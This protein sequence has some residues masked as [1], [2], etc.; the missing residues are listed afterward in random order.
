M[1]ELLQKQLNQR[2]EANALR[3]LP[4]LPGL[5]DFSSNDYLGLA[6]IDLN[7]SFHKNGSGGSRLISGNSKLMEQIEEDLARFYHTPSALLF[8]SG[9]D[10]NVGL[11]SCLL[12]KG[13]TYIYDQ[14]IHAS[15][16]DGMRL[17]NANSYAFRH[18]D[19]ESLAA[20]LE[21][22]KGR[23]V[24]VIESI[25]SMDGDMAPIKEITALCDRNNAELIVD[26]AHSTGVFGVNGC[27][28]VSHYGLQD[29]VYAR[30][31]T[32]GKAMGCHGAVIVGSDVLKSY[33]VNF[34]RSFIYTTALPEHSVQTIAEVHKRMPE[35]GDARKALKQNISLFQDCLDATVKNYL[36]PS[37]SAIQCILFADNDK[38]KALASY[39]Q[40]EGFDVRPIMSPT[41]EQGK[42][43]IRI[44]IHSFNT[45][46]EIKGLATSINTYLK[47][48]K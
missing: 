26:E 27:G 17:S 34:A 40:N 22:A 45:E 48:A 15:V 46:E 23:K 20:K 47:N 1:D 13:D 7:I 33:L 12:Q 41:V 43:R 39:L 21:L 37:C 10:A 38:V 2:L 19:L 29:K 31:H 3:Q 32:F 11:F 30:I 36:I 42:E 25:Y 8:N 5:V 44:C 28:L 35:I 9:Y 18:N 24:V 6:Q 16:R 4:K 14:L